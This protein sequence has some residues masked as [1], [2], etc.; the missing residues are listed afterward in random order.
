[1]TEEKNKRTVTKEHKGCP[2]YIKN[3]YE[4]DGIKQES[5]F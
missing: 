4:Q 3:Y 2:A 1:M 5:H